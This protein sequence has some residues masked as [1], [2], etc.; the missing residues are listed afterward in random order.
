MKVR[1]RNNRK[2]G[3]LQR[4]LV[5]VC[6]ALAILGAMAGAGVFTYYYVRFSRL[7]DQRLSGH[8]FGNASRI[9]A[10]PDSV[11]AGQEATVAEVAAGLRRA[12]YSERKENALGWYHLLDGGIEIFPGP[13]S[14][15]RDEPALLRISAHKVQRIISLKDNTDR[16]RYDLEPELI[17][18]LFDRSREKRRLVRFEDLP[19]HLVSAVLAIED[20]NFFQHPGIDFLRIAKAAYLDLRAGEKIQ[21]ASTLTMQL[22]G[23]FF[24]DRRQRTWKRKLAET[25]I[26]L[27]LEKRL[28]KKEIFE[29]YVNQINLGQRGSF[30]INGVGEA[31]LAYFGK[32]VKQLTLPEA[33]LLA[34]IVRGPSY[35]SP[36]RHPDR[37]KERRNRVLE[38]MARIDAL[39]KEEAEIAMRAPVKV[40]P[41]YVD[42]GDAPYFVDLLRDQLLE[43]YAE[44][45]LLAA[46]YRIYSTLD[47]DLQKAASAAVRVG[48][49]EVD[50][51]LARRRHKGKPWPEAQVA[52]VALDPHTGAVK[53]LVG[54]RNYGASQLDHAVAKRQPGSSFKPF[55]YAAA[56]DS[57][58]DGSRPLVTP[59][60]VVVDEPTTFVYDG[61]IYEPSNFGEKFYGATTVRNA[62]AHSMNVA[63]VKVAEMVG[64]QKVAQVAREAGIHNVQPTPSL[65]LGSYEA[66]PVEMAG[67]Y[68]V[69][70]NAGERLDPFLVRSV[71]N[72]DGSTVEETQPRPVRVLDPRVAYLMTNLLE[73][74]MR[75]GTAAGARGRGFTAPAAGKTGTSHDAWFA[76]Y[77]SNLL[78]VVWVGFDDN[79]EL[80]L[81]GAKAALPVWTEFMKRAVTER[82]YRN[83]LP[84]PPPPGIVTLE[85]DADTGLLAT[86][87]CV[88]RTTEV[89]IDGTQPEPC[90]HA[91]QKVMNRPG[92]FSRLFGI[93]R[94][95]TVRPPVTGPVATRQA[96][97]IAAQPA[98]AH[99]SAGPPE[100][101]T[102]DPPAKKKRG[103]FGR[104][105]GTSRDREDKDKPKPP[106]P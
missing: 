76:G 5:K 99:P 44:K 52:L 84:F 77:T 81:E 34:G 18:N 48:M 26:T 72:Q 45:E 66:T 3:A 82:P 21:G 32:D 93:S 85:V 33:A 86:P 6:L 41:T 50:Q 100:T 4:P 75:Y 28:T 70:A 68:T 74:V 95:E 67:A 16:Q 94:G 101:D 30:S 88:N 91:L 8:I 25:L 102:Q 103:F 80:P 96:P 55:V 78:A 35:Y 13:E 104:I 37:A 10:A 29:L 15:F 46:G 90:T 1:L 31:S 27:Q 73:G 19:P 17:T 63:T 64:Y 22:A 47:L 43:R 23:M 49:Q 92:F 87:Y 61:G 79:T 36:Y 12:G 97:E 65:A 60:T 24:L 89:F 38:S 56:L 98:P 57:G 40:V 105:F 106:R 71:R 39:S 2:A 54:G 58:I 51:Q 62:L 53:A 83:T 11:F 69:F 59:T 42:T 9:Y 7:I 20:K 14:Y